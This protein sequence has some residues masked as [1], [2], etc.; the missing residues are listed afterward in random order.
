MAETGAQSSGGS[1]SPLHP[2][3]LRAIRKASGMSLDEVADAIGMSKQAVQA[4]ESGRNAIKSDNLLK[5][6]EALGCTPNDILGYT[7]EGPLAGRLRAMT[8]EL[9]E[10]CDLYLDNDLTMQTTIR[11]ILYS[12]ARH[13]STRHH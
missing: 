2:N 4:W 5:L 12:N 1:A 8:D 9:D 7:K 6:S 10:V 3:Q 11:Q 13:R